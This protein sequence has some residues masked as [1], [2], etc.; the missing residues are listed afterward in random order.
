[1]SNYTDG[2]NGPTYKPTLTQ[3]QIDAAW[4]LEAISQQTAVPQRELSRR[5]EDTGVINA[6]PGDNVGTVTPQEHLSSPNKRPL[7]Q[8][9]VSDEDDTPKPEPDQDTR[10][11][12]DSSTTPVSKAAKPTKQPLKERSIFD[13]LTVHNLGKPIEYTREDNLFRSL[14]QPP[15]PPKKKKHSGRP[16][17][18]Y[19]RFTY[20]STT[21]RKRTVTSTRMYTVPTSDHLTKHFRLSHPRKRLGA[22]YHRLT[23]TAS[24]HSVSFPCYTVC[25]MSRSLRGQET[26]MQQ[27][28]AIAAQIVKTHARRDSLV[29]EEAW[30]AASG[31]E[32]S[33]RSW[34][35]EEDGE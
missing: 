7:Y 5:K 19:H 22:Y 26:K 12:K 29:L 11:I 24:K 15:L 32:E 4:G 10:V 1:M 28:M 21:S 30:K 25:S 27:Q 18:I 2:P 20:S 17:G 31:R 34:K 8:A 14:A 23:G 6:T 9:Y 13:D 35:S 16:T 3:L 33:E